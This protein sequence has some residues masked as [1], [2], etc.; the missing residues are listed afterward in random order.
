MR[1]CPPQPLERAAHPVW[2]CP[3][4]RAHEYEWIADFLQI[5]VTN[6]YYLDILC[7]TLLLLQDDLAI[8]W[9]KCT[10][11]KDK[12]LTTPGKPTARVPGR[13]MK[14]IATDGLNRTY[15]QKLD[16]QT[17]VATGVAI[18]LVTLSFFWMLFR[19]GGDHSVT[20]YSDIMYRVDA[21]IGDS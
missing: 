15:L 12:A 4:R 5:A 8:L 10:H 16:R 20:L 11:G 19:I 2:H 3:R 17:Y 1:E 9:T 14:T 18:L 21:W 7:S 13:H 6:I